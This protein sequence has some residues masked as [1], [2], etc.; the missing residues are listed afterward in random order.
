MVQEPIIR[1]VK[2][3]KE[4][5]TTSML[6]NGQC[7]INSSW[8]YICRSMHLSTLI[9]VAS[10]CSRLWL[11]CDPQLAKVQRIRDSIVD[12]A[13]L[14]L[15]KK[16]SWASQGKQASKQ[17]PSMACASA[18]AP[19]FLLCVS[20]SPDFLGDEQQCGNVSLSSPTASWSWCLCR[21]RNPWLRQ[22][23]SQDSGNSLYWWGNEKSIRGWGSG[24]LTTGKCY[25]LDTA[26][27]LFIWTHTV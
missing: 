12:G 8:L 11:A 7:E 14:G 27:Q 2:K 23:P 13:I 1:Q 24:W 10:I 22:I 6:L 4:E 18:P 16:A 19:R 9:W 15:V 3:P 25:L 20:S 21:N 5:P 17:H 26:W